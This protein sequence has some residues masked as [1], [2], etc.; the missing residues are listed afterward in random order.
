MKP[1]PIRLAGCQRYAE[2]NRSDPFAYNRAMSHLRN[3]ICGFNNNGEEAF[4]DATRDVEERTAP[5]GTKYQVPVYRN[6]IR[7]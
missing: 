4:Y 3:G 7:P 2:A 5:D 1:L 6:V